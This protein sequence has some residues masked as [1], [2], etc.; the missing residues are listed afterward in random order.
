MQLS[1]Q[2]AQKALENLLCTMR[3]WNEFLVKTPRHFFSRALQKERKSREGQARASLAPMPRDVCSHTPSKAATLS[4]FSL[5]HCLPL[6]RQ[7]G[8]PTSVVN[9]LILLRQ[10]S[11]SL[12]QNGGLCVESDGCCFSTTLSFTSKKS[13]GA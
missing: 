8:I 5:C 2:L 3:S 7:S 12:L 11:I 9:H 1:Q 10:T 13:L 4:I 6:I